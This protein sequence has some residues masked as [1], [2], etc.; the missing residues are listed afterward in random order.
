MSPYK[1]GFEN[2]FGGGGKMRRFAPLFAFVVMIVATSVANADTVYL[3][4]GSVIKGKVTAFSAGQFAVVLNTGSLGGSRAQID[5]GDV[6]RIEFDSMTGVTGG[7]GG[8]VQSQPGN[9]RAD[10]RNDQPSVR[11]EGPPPT[12]ARDTA[13]PAVPRDT[14]ASVPRDTSA[15][16][17][18]DKPSGGGEAP[19]DTAPAESNPAPRDT[20]SATPPVTQPAPP[21]AEDADPT[22]P[23]RSSKG[24]V[25]T[26]NVD[27][28]AK[29][30]WTSSGL[31]VKRG[32]R[33]RI[34][35]SGTVTLDP[36]S[37]V[38]SPPEGIDQQDPKKLMQDRPTGALIAVIG[39]DNDD[40]IFIGRSSEFT[41]A[42]DGLLFLSVN[43][44]TL[45][46]NSGSF[47]A[48]IEVAP[49]K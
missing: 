25:K 2:L 22:P 12:S 5:I 39:A 44:G 6:D 9:T 26:A 13:S 31:I 8:P 20:E 15:T 27:V 18:R 33:I 38:T 14:P 32:D 48:V 28:I 35:A 10:G 30:D 17:A 49:A 16:D 11:D 29:R 23:L 1:L 37:G 34:R 3:K 41:A 24:P 45:S 36:N 19:R 4:N 40:F 42:R 46:D 7:D 47:K 43:E 21:A